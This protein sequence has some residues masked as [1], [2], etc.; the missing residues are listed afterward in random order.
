M[1]RGKRLPQGPSDLSRLV[2]HL[3]AAPK[4][5]LPSITS[6]RLTLA[7]R[8]D[9]FGARHFLKE[10]LP[11]IRFANPDLDIQVRKMNK[12]PEDEW[13]PELQVSFRDGETQTLN[14]Y[15]KLSSAIV[16]ELMDS[17]AS[18]SWERWKSEAARTGVPLVPG[19]EKEPPANDLV[20]GDKPE[21]VLSFDEWRQQSRKARRRRPESVKGAAAQNKPQDA[22]APPQEPLTEAQILA[23]AEKAAQDAEVRKEARKEARRAKLD[24]PRLAQEEAEQRVALELLSKPR[25]GAAAVL[26]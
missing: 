14:L 26:P 7:A 3:R 8:N 1:A 19:A 20:S 15:G 10:Q 22:K 21:P 17:V 18:P 25:T 6:L 9:H 23:N 2:A 11:R 5:A 12:R 13:R 4:L 16:R 24:A